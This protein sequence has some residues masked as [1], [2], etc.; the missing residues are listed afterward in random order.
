MASDQSKI[1]SIGQQMRAVKFNSI[2]YFAKP[3]ADIRIARGASHGK[4]RDD[5]LLQSPDSTEDVSILK[6]QLRT[7]Y[8]KLME[9]NRIIKTDKGL[10]TEF[11]KRVEKLMNNLKTADNELREKNTDKYNGVLFRLNLKWKKFVKSVELKEIPDSPGVEE[12]QMDAPVPERGVKTLSKK[13]TRGSLMFEKKKLKSFRALL[14]TA[15]HTAGHKNVPFSKLTRQDPKFAE[16]N[17][18]MFMNDLFGAVAASE[19]FNDIVA[20]GIPFISKRKAPGMFGKVNLYKYLSTY[21]SNHRTKTTK[22]KKSIQKT[23]IDNLI[24]KKS[25]TSG[26]EA[27]LKK[28]GAEPGEPGE[29]QQPAQRKKKPPPEVKTPPRQVK[30]PPE[31]VKT[32]PKKKPPPEVFTPS[33]PPH[34][35]ALDSPEASPEKKKD[36]VEIR[37]HLDITEKY[38]SAVE[39]LFDE[40]LSPKT[41]IDI[42]RNK[43]SEQALEIDYP[44]ITNE[45]ATF[46]RVDLFKRMFKNCKNRKQYAKMLKYISLAFPQNK[47]IISKYFIYLEQPQRLHKN[48]RKHAEFAQELTKW[49]KNIKLLQRAEQNKN[50]AKWNELIPK[51]KS[52]I[53]QFETY[54][55]QVAKN[56]FHNMPNVVQSLSLKEA[57]AETQRYEPKDWEG[58]DFSGVYEG[59]ETPL[60][61]PEYSEPL[62]KPK[63]KPK[64]PEQVE[65]KIYTPPRPQKPKDPKSFPGWQQL[66]G[67]LKKPDQPKSP[68]PKSPQPKSP[69]PKSPQRK[70]PPKLRVKSPPKLR[71]KTPTRPKPRQ[72]Q[73]SGQK[74]P[75]GPMP[76]IQNVPKRVQSKPLQKAVGKPIIKKARVP[77]MP[78]RQ[79]GFGQQQR[80]PIVP[81]Q[82]RPLAQAPQAQQAQ[83]QQ[84]VGFGPRQ[85]LRHRGRLSQYKIPIHLEHPSIST[86]AMAQIMRNDR[87]RKDPTMRFKEGKSKK[88]GKYV[89]M[90]TG[91]GTI[92]INVK[93]AASR[94]VISLLLKHLKAFVAQTYSAELFSINEDFKQAFVS[95][96]GLITIGFET[97]HGM[98]KKFLTKD[99]NEFLLEYESKGNLGGSLV[100]GRNGDYLYDF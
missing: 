61:V 4:E 87:L 94:R 10:Q 25:F 66:I 1:Q 39:E 67:S 37:K 23:W 74:K 73:P 97:F 31:K 79:P 68:Q 45:N 12:K 44:A 32:P 35:V 48:P 30:P 21:L 13:S 63:R 19:L 16:K 80:A 58:G 69:Q 7:V 92:F 49:V 72:R 57:L 93:K 99:N 15:M 27:F 8:G 9:I 59:G 42:F 6:E 29:F 5:T 22:I 46:I 76:R 2:P 100:S 82:Q 83:A 81:P 96:Q 51:L 47:E 50:D 98:L 36:F 3:N 88:I 90:I 11:G 18:T 84:P 75:R 86:Q 55:F 62:Q 40:S 70:S 89:Q 26:W 95:R 20:N 53:D 33:P 71:G 43:F 91:K 24:K 65:E 17:I 64:P 54:R 38:E 85:R 78:K 34:P 60:Y 41:K 28:L 14:N 56:F 52:K 77:K